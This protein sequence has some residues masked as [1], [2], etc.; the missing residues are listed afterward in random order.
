MVPPARPGDEIRS[1][2]PTVWHDA[3]RMTMWKAHALAHPHPDQLD[4]RTGDKV[5]AKIDL[6]GVPAGTPGRVILANGFNWLRYRV[7][8]ANGAELGDLD[9]RHLVPVG[10]TRK[11]LQKP[12]R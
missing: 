10:R 5:E 1:S 8:F 4:L 11:R 6:A 12:R 3:R 9:G 7:L 2:E